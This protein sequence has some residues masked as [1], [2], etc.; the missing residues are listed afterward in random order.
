LLDFDDANHTYV[1]FDLVCL[2]DSWG[3]P[4]QSENLDLS[5]AREIVDTYRRYRPL[6]AFEQRHIFDVHK[7][8]IL[9]DCVWYFGRG[10]ADDFYEKRKIEFLNNLGWKKYTDAILFA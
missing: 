8:S 5:K 2:V 4:Y 7:L 1:V 9:F 10:D 6:S 3:W